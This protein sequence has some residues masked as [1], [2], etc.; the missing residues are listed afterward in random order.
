MSDEQQI[1]VG[2]PIDSQ[3]LVHARRAR[4]RIGWALL[5]CNLGM[6]TALAVIANQFRLLA[7]DAIKQAANYKQQLEQVTNDRDVLQ[8]RLTSLEEQCG[9]PGPNSLPAPSGGGV[10][11]GSMAL[12]K[13]PI[14][15]EL[16]ITR[17]LLE[18]CLVISRP[19]TFTS[20]RPA[21]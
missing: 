5:I 15:I 14:A 9:A 12:R 8:N 16:E 21:R 2:V 19:P 17:R 13:P 10:M 18:A 4:N 1:G 7:R 6:I 3:T 20:W 11:P